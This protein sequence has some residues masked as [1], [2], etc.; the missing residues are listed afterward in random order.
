M[1]LYIIIG[2]LALV[3]ILLIILLFR[4]PKNDDTVEIIKEIN[5]LDKNVTK[6]INEFKYDFVKDLR[7]DFDKLNRD[8]EK[9][10]LLKSID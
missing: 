5:E 10:L 9:R 3:L 7:E 6:D 8:M 4:K 2:L 1:E